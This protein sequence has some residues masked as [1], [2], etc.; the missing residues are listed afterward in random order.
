MYGHTACS[1][2]A[3]LYK[4][5]E[6]YAITGMRLTWIPSNIRGIIDPAQNTNVGGFVGPM[7][8]YDDINTYNTLALTDEQILTK[9]NIMIRDPTRVWS[10]YLT[11]RNLAVKM[12]QKWLDPS[13]FPISPQAIDALNGSTSLR[14]QTQ[15]INQNAKLGYFR[16]S[17]YITFRG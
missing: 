15:G 3:Q 5:F 14:F 8:V 11:F 2:Y 6:Q 17:W 9:D 12:Q 1:R 4:D 7:Y 10:K 16:V 13:T